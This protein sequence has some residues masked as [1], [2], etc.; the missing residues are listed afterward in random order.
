MARIPGI[1]PKAHHSTETAL[2]RVFNDISQALDARR[3]VLL[4][5]IDL[6]AAFDTINHGKLIRLLDEEYGIRDT[7]LTWFASYFEN[8]H[9]YVKID[10]YKSQESP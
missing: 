9:H 7:A 1:S 6:S 5:M 10:S 4:A 8:R 3:V 2:L